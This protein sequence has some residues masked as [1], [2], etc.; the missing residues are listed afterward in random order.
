[1][2]GIMCPKCG[3]GNTAV[4]NSRGKEGIIKRRR[5]CLVCG[6]KMNTIETIETNV[7]SRKDHGLFLAIKSVGSAKELAKRIG[8]S[9]QA[10]VYWQKVPINRIDIVEKISG[11]RREVLRP[12]L[13]GK[14]RTDTTRLPDGRLMWQAPLIE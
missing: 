1:M 8:I 11:I 3:S 12:D 9:P 2:N 6:F 5:N 10:I 4:I 13:F 7:K 14:L